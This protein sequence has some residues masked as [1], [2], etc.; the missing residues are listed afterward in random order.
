MDFIIDDCNEIRLKMIPL[1]GKEQYEEV[2]DLSEFPFRAGKTTRIKVE[3]DFTADD[4]CLVT[5]KDKGFGEIARSSGK[6]I[7]KNLK[8]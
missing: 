1:A 7:H 3:F 5:V 4:R 2:I 6:V 8:I